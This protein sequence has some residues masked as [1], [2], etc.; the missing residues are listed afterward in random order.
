MENIKLRLIRWMVQAIWMSVS[1]LGKMC[2]EFT[3]DVIE[4]VIL[5]SQCSYLNLS[6]IVRTI[7]GIAPYQ[8]N[9]PFTS[10]GRS[11]VAAG[12]AVYSSSIEL[13][14]SLGPSGSDGAAGFTLD[15][16]LVHSGNHSATECFRLS[17]PNLS[18]PTQGS[19]YSLNEGREPDWPGGLRQWIHDAKRGNTPSGTVYSSRYI[20]SLCADVHRT[21]L[22]GGWAG[23]PRPHLRLLY[24]AA[25]MA[26]VAQACGGRGSDGNGNLLDVV[27]EGL[28]G[29]TCVLL[30]SE[31]DILELESYGDIQQS[32][33]TY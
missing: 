6:Y 30:G 9:D 33:K 8:P 12:Y 2:V 4:C 10:T 14:I 5:S 17:R 7:F 16:S 29:R 23:N 19:T 1:Q 32:S 13:V 26:H 25:P 3:M 31:G 21:I 11:L 27:P 24:E 18:C 28:H 22:T 15:P 20:C